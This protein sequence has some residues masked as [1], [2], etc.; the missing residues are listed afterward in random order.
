MHRKYRNQSQ[1]AQFIKIR[2][3][4]PLG[5]KKNNKVSVNINQQEQE[6]A[7]NSEKF[8]PLELFLQN[9]CVNELLHSIHLSL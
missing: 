6:Y 7:C 8:A 3:N 9:F 2:E 5:K 1:N 4:M